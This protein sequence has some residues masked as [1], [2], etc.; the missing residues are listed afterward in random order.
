MPVSLASPS[1]TGIRRPARDTTS[2][3][4]WPRTVPRLRNAAVTLREISPRDAAALFVHL[5]DPVVLRHVSPC[6]GS[7][8]GLER[9]ARW[10]QERRRRGRLICFSIIPAGHTRPAGL[11]QVWPLDPNGVTAEFGVVMGRAFWGTGL[12]PAAAALLFQF[13]FD[14]LGVLRLEARTNALNRRANAA[15]KKVGASV[16]GRLRTI[17]SRTASRVLWLIQPDTARIAAPTAR[18]RIG[19]AR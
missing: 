17:G 14:R 9:F 11:V 3:P 4:G 15:L 2:R 12:F 1:T 13:V 19:D 7:I 18:A 10:A 6:P 8:A 16:E 5:D